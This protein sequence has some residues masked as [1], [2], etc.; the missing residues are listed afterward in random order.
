MN[1]R[2]FLL[3][4]FLWLNNMTST[5]SLFCVLLRSLIFRPVWPNAPSGVVGP[6][7]LNGMYKSKCSL[8][9]TSAGS[10]EQA[11]AILRPFCWHCQHSEGASWNGWFGAEPRAKTSSQILKRR[12]HH[13]H[14]YG[15][16][17]LRNFV[18]NILHT[19]H[20]VT[21]VGFG[22][23]MVVLVPE[24][25]HACLINGIAYTKLVASGTDRGSVAAETITNRPVVTSRIWVVN[26]QRA[27][28]SA[29]IHS[30][31]KW[32]AKSRPVQVPQLP[33]PFM[34]NVVSKLSVLSTLVTLHVQPA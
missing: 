4:P 15:V 6:S 18:R 14:P 7:E 8:F 10:E 20:G 28:A 19:V 32:Q 24:E 9:H 34:L 5:L 2:S 31:E 30:T 26:M 11:A 22:L 27:R 29:A 25:L 1:Y 17:D 3:T 23:G 21:L 13:P 12:S 33:T 16:D